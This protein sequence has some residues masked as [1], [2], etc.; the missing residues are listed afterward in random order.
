MEFD[1]CH[2][3]DDGEY[4]GVSFV[5]ITKISVMQGAFYIGKEPFD[6]VYPPSSHAPEKPTLPITALS[7]IRN[8]LTATF[9]SYGNAHNY[10]YFVFLDHQATVLLRFHWKISQLSVWVS[11][12]HHV[13]GTVLKLNPSQLHHTEQHVFFRILSFIIKMQGTTFKSALKK[14][15]HFCALPL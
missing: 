6:G 8:L 1:L 4:N 3:R 2:A 5:E 9:S 11:A 14:C 13:I 10:L 15:G 12:W 7:K